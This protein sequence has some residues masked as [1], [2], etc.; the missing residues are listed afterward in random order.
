MNKKL[1]V[2][3]I[4]LMSPV[5]VFAAGQSM[6]MDN[7]SSMSP[8]A[9]EYMSGMQSMHDNMMAGMMSS[10]PDVAF[11]KGMTAHHQGAIEMAKTELKY[12]KDPEMRKLAQDIINA[13]QPEIDQMQTWVKNNNK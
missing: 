1:L 2:V 9:Q 10:N 11:A 13:Q 4:A 5:A 12:G 7:Q 6:N 3:V 8:A